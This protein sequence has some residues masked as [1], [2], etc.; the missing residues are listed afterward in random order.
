MFQKPA[1]VLR[2]NFSM[3]LTDPNN[4]TTIIEG[5]EGTLD[6]NTCYGYELDFLRTSIKQTNAYADSIETAANNGNNL[7]HISRRQSTSRTN[8]DHCSA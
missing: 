4:L 6:L 2:T 1:R 5:E 3:A 8:E 7:A